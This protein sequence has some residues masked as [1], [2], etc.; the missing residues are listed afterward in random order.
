LKGFFGRLLGLATD[1]PAEAPLREGSVLRQH[2]ITQ[3]Y[4]RVVDTI[5]LFNP[6]AV[7]INQRLL[8]R[9]N[10][11]VAFAMAVNRGPLINAQWTISSRDDKIKAFVDQQMRKH[12]RAIARSASLGIGYGYQVT[13]KVWKS[14]PVTVEIEDK[15]GGSKTVTSIPM[16][17]TFDRFKSIDPRTIVLHVDPKTDQWDGVQQYVYLQPNVNQNPSALI[18]PER[19]GLWIHGKDDNFGRLTG[20][21]M[22]DQMFTPWW[23][24]ESLGMYANRYFET[25]GDPTPVGRAL[26]DGLVMPDGTR[27]D[28]LEFMS[29]VLKMLKGGNGVVIPSDRDDKGN[30][31]YDIEFKHDDKRGDQFE[32]ILKYWDGKILQ[33]GLTPPRVGGAHAGSGLGTKDAGVQQDQH[34]EFMESILYDFIDYVNEQ[35]VDPMVIYNFGQEAFEQSKTRLVVSGLSAGMK[36]MLKEILFKAFDEEMTLGSGKN[37]P[38]YKRLDCPAI[39]K[40]LDVPMPSA[41][42]L[43]ELEADQEEANQQAQQMQDAALQGGGMGGGGKPPPSGEGDPSEMSLATFGQDH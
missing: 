12:Y 6:K 38:L 10:A 30:Y 37:I 16:A 1:S 8:M 32:S 34:A 41:E 4:A 18:G 27:M 21:A 11:D 36:S 33:A 5:G 20:R 43:A 2:F 26:L 29:G 24:V 35:Y 31:K 15:V 40:E 23:N 19:V 22:L 17:W 3:I 7:T 39:M 42:E 9:N 28:G 25:K 14:G 13:E